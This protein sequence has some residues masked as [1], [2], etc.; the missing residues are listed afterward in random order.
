[1]TL[2]KFDKVDECESWLK[3]YLGNQTIDTKEVYGAGQARGFS[4]SL[5]L[6]AA[7]RL[8]VTSRYGV[9]RNRLW[10]L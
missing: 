2:K 8:N 5:I 6:K 10:S 1:M 9:G 3:R 4:E 7:H